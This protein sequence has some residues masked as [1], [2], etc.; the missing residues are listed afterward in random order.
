MT[1]ESPAAESPALGSPSVE[2]PSVES[3][4]ADTFSRPAT[5]VFS[6]PGRVNLIGEHTDYN[7][8]LVLPF[9]IDA[10]ARVAIAPAGHGELR[11]VS[12]QQ[13]GDPVAYELGDETPGRVPGWAGY[14]AGAAWALADR[15]CPLD[16]LDGVDLALDSAVPIGAGLSSSAALECAGALALATL[17]GYD[18]E[19][20]VLARIAQHDENDYVGVP[21]GLMD[22]MASATAR[23]GSVLAF[24]VGRDTLAHIPF[25]PA[26][27]DLAVLLID[28][29]AHHSL[30]DGEYADRRRACERAAA[31]LGLTSLRELDGVPLDPT[32]DRL[33]GDELRRRVRH[34]VTEN[35]RV[36][37][38]M[39][40]LRA[41]RPDSIGP[42][43][44][45][46]HISLR[47]DFEVSCAELDVAVEAA[48]GSGALG[49]RMTGGGFGGSVIALVQASQVGSVST[50]AAA[51][52]AARGWTVPIFREVT[53]AD[54]ARVDRLD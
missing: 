29:Q 21:C 52:F 36:R 54:G 51:A 17:A 6:A 10:R 42:D 20:A 8:G 48:M 39:S 50:A 37:R 41:G 2:S 45:A 34:V 49:A 25:D 38:V 33:S 18:L 27:A 32:L 9:A 15:G 40:A 5:G 16:S 44:L 47:D 13:P 19:P 12:A 30:A 11:M 53:P 31:E 22:Q 43:L 46:S 23:A 1:A 3:L 28:T 14:L 35:E 4:F 26:A 7:D 24:D